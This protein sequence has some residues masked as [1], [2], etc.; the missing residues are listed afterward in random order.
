MEGRVLAIYCRQSNTDLDE[1]GDSL[2]IE[3]Q[4]RACRDYVTRLG[5]TVAAVYADEDEKGWQASRPAFDRMLAAVRSGAVN[6]VVVFKLSRFMRS[7]IDQER[8]VGEIAAAGGELVSVMEPY[9]STSPMVRQI[10]GA[11]NEQY[12]R[13]QAEF[14][15]AAFA[16]RS[17]RGLHHGPAPYGYTKAESILTPA[18]PAA[19][20]V[21]E[22]YAWAAAGDGSPEIAMRLNA[23][24]I[25][26]SRSG[27][28]WSPSRVL[29]LLRRPVYGG[30]IALNGEIIGE[31]AHEPLVDRD[32]WEA[33]QGML[34]R[35]RGTRRKVAPS[36]ID[37][38]VEHACGHRMHA[39]RERGGGW[40]Y[41]CGHV[42]Y[43]R[44][45]GRPVCTTRPASMS[46]AKIEAA[47]L[48]LLTDALETLASPTAVIAR[49]RAGQTERESERVRRRQRLERRIADVTTQ[50]DRL[51]DMTLRGAVEEDAYRPRDAAL[52]AELNDLR[53]ELAGVP[54]AVDPDRVAARHAHL[55]GVA[56]ELEVARAGNPGALTGILH[57][58]DVRIVVGA[59]P[60]RLRWPAALRA[61]VCG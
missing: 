13:D 37:G 48:P 33:V 60:L 7:L 34:D 26:T 18:E 49:M 21:R 20:V 38:F 61:F 22:M 47:L 24:G 36:W 17:R 1:R 10:L 2:S 23:R 8:F 27:A 45:V 58:L 52:R 15:R 57:A 54:S 40:R 9:I 12:R 56:Q 11:V 43:P 25:G 46:A 19:S 29:E 31:G 28:A 30:L 59:G 5:G 14:L 16:E 53:A 44:Y 42:Q 4:T 3:A 39:V 32:T 41:R 50:R 55:I 51:L 6:G 35:R